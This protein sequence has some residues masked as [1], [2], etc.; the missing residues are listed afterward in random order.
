M[1]R[2]ASCALVLAA[3]FACT[4][5]DPPFP[6][7]SNGA[8][9]GAPNDAA[10]NACG[11][12]LSKDP[13]HCG[14]CGHD[15]LPG[16]ECKDGACTTIDLVDEKPDAADA[17]L[18][19]IALAGTRL[20]WV[21]Q[22][23]A[24]GPFTIKSCDVAQCA[25]STRVLHQTDEEIRA[26]AADATKVYF[27]SYLA[28]GKVYTCPADGCS[29]NPAVLV[30]GPSF[31]ATLAVDESTVF[32]SSWGYDED[33]GAC[34]KTGCSQER[35]LLVQ[36]PEFPRFMLHDTHVWFSS[37]VPGDDAGLPGAPGIYRVAK[38]AEAGAPEVMVGSQETR[39]SPIGIAVS[40]AAL[41]FFT[42]RGRPEARDGRIYKVE[43]KLATAI[44]TGLATPT[45]ILLDD[46]TLYFALVGDGTLRRC[47]TTDCTNPETLATGQG[48]SPV[49][50][51]SAA[52]CLLQD[53]TSVYWFNRVD[54]A[55]KRLAK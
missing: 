52:T 21:A 23:T 43:T 22:R 5:E 11:A 31:P 34:P 10:E 40:S 55:I 35:K 37:L 16:G 2:F 36:R 38:T 7:A 15:C 42:D 12:D 32:W 17:L 6:G 30:T 45:A 53:A 8:D 25:A 46:K 3:A 39:F 50:S 14:R 49:D 48:F 47:T 44:A 24:T 28:P 18:R 33:I 41:F 54:G 19:A 1:R 29:G 27:A 4:G 20:Y 13:R 51:S 26:I 9:S